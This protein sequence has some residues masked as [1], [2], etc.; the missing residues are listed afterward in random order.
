MR[1]KFPGDFKIP[2]HWH[3]H[4]ERFMVLSDSMCE[5][6]G[7]HADMS[8]AKLMTAGSVGIMQAKTPDYVVTREET[9]VQVHTTGPLQS[10]PV[11]K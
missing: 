8:K 11:K 1:V 4:G 10:F 3:P 6:F 2:P 9:I 5:G 7:E